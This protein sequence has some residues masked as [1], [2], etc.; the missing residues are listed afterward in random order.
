MTPAGFV[1][2]HG[3]ACPGPTFL[4]VVVVVGALPS[5][6]SSPFV[7]TSSAPSLSVDDPTHTR[8]VGIVVVEP[9]AL[10]VATSALPGGV[11]VGTSKRLVVGLQTSFCWLT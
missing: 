5:Y 6:D 1:D 11:F 3:F 4:S 2:N 7:L 8:L 9:L 10:R